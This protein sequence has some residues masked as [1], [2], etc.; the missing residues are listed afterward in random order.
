MSDPSP[1]AAPQ[2]T[3]S[4]PAPAQGVAGESGDAQ[5]TAPPPALE[6]AAAPAVAPIPLA[7]PTAPSHAPAPPPAPAAPPPLPSAP[8]PPTTAPPTPFDD[9]LSDAARAARSASQWNGLLRWARGVRLE[10]SQG[11]VGGGW[12]WGSGGYHVPRDSPQYWCGRERAPID[13]SA[14]LPSRRPT[15][16]APHAHDAGLSDDDDAGLQQQENAYGRPRRRA[17]A[18]A[19]GKVISAADRDY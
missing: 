5:Q 10:G 7:A 11:G 6:A 15:T 16:I 4:G 3:E 14:P 9:P 13:P 17:A 19:A 8:P 12:D 18:V 1:T 2:P